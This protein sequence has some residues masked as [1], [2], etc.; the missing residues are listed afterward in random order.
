VALLAAR[1]CGAD[2]T[3]PVVHNEPITV[4]VVDGTDGRPVAHAHVALAAGYDRRD[5][6]LGLWREETLTDGEGKARLSNGLRN[7]PWLQVRVAKRHLCEGDA[8][9]SAYSVERIRRDG[10]SA[11]N[12]CGTA[13]VEAA[14]GVVTVFVKGGKADANAAAP[15]EGA[16]LAPVSRA[17]SAPASVSA[18][19]APPSEH[20]PAAAADLGAVSVPAMAH[21]PSAAR[22]AA[23]S[24][25]P[26]P[27][28]APGENG[29]DPLCLPA[30]P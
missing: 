11:A 5:L 4:R 12:R 10:L 8:G 28:F 22:S 25:A 30:S 7:L 15:D 2:E 6:R 16:T 1:T 14:P 9:G 17:A 29:L 24:M 26:A 19:P 18:T 23:P 27:A 13:T 20:A 21:A 3:F